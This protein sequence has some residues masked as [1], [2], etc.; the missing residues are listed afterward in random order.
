M[1]YNLYLYLFLSNLTYIIN[2]YDYLKKDDGDGDIYFESPIS[3]AQT[4]LCFFGGELQ[5]PTRQGG[6]LLFPGWL[7]HGVTMHN[8]DKERISVSFNV[9]FN[10]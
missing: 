2:R 1:S 6:L 8:S 7:K 10:R 5:V 9:V 4:S 3:Q